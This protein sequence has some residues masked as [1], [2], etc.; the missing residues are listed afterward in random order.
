MKTQATTPDWTTNIETVGSS[1]SF[2]DADS[3]SDVTSAIVLV[4]ALRTRNAAPGSGPDGSNIFKRPDALRMEEA[5][6]LAGAIDLQ[7]AEA[8]IVPISAIHVR[9]PCS[10]R[11]RC[12]RSRH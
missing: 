5:V 1:G 11:A 8:L 9:R 12:S 2:A 7:V 6:G 3:K 4:P 10:A